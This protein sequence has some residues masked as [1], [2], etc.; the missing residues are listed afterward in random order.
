MILAAGLGT[1]L[2]PHTRRR[3]KP[4]FPV[5]GEPLIK[6]IV[7][8]LRAAGL[9]P[10]VVNAHHLAEQIADCLAGEPDIILQ[11]EE[12]ELGT[13]GGLR[14]ALPHFQ[15]DPVLVTNGDIFHDIDYRQ[16]LA[17][18][19][20]SGGPLTMVMQ[21]LP[22]FNSV[23]VAGDRVLGLP[24]GGRPAEVPPGARCLAFTGIHV[25]EPAL[26]AGIPSGSFH[27]I[28]DRYQGHLAA[29]GQSQALT[30]RGHFW[31]DIGTPRDYLELHRDLLLANDTAPSFRLA[32]GVRMGREV[33]LDG[34]GYVGAGAVIGDR[35]RL[36]RV[37][38]WEG[39]EIPAGQ[40]L[41]DCLVTG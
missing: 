26:L 1:R 18:H 10:V 38:V 5:L 34:W 4:L 14:L 16:V 22:R 28:L 7:G 25:V 19:Q 32:A 23:P 20:A 35:A 30:V 21:D 9:G 17:G 31:R 36:A 41:A 37:V 15:D 27:S 40:A 2:L 39:V 8:Q 33:A 6:R 3:P 12:R 13:G 29:G 24:A 11:R